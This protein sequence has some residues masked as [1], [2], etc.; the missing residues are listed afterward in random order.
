ME[1]ATGAEFISSAHVRHIMRYVQ[2]RDWLTDRPYYIFDAA[3]GTG[4]GSKILAKAG[5]Q[6]HGLDFDEAALEEARKEPVKG[7]VFD[8]TD[9][10]HDPYPRKAS[11]VVCIETIEHVSAEDGFKILK[12]FHGWLSYDGVLILSSPYCVE[13]GPSPITL[14]HLW[15]YNLTDLEMAVSSSGFDIDIIKPWRHEGKAGR[16]GYCMLRATKR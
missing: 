11:A 13:S 16:L 15:E 7:C 6:V 4:Y 2:A 5:H 10:I 9:L 14:Q 1:T 12:K 8:N 3:C